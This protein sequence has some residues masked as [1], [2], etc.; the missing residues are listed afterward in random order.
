MIQYRFLI[1]APQSLI[2]SRVRCGDLEDVVLRV[3]PRI[4]CEQRHKL[5]TLRLE[6]VHQV[7]KNIFKFNCQP[8]PRYDFNAVEVYNSKKRKT[9]NINTNDN[10]NY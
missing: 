6:N 4:L 9:S 7:K 1:L 5:L 10:N 8:S 2:L 3:L